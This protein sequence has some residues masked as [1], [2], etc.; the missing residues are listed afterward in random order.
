VID[1]ELDID[2]QTAIEDPECPQ[3]QE[4]SAMPNDPGLIWPTRKSK[5]QADTVLVMVNAIKRRQNTGVKKKQDRMCQWLTS[6][7]I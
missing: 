4:M 1:N 2:Q 3:Q 6:F 5:R 7:F